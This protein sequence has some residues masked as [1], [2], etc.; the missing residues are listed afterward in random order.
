[1]KHE[2]TMWVKC[3]GCYAVYYTVIHIRAQY[4]SGIYCGGD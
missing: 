3:K 1:M 2:N 4:M